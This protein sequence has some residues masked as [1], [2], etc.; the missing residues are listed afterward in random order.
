MFFICSTSFQLFIPFPRFWVQINQ[1]IPFLILLQKNP[2]LRITGP[3]VKP[4][5]SNSEDNSGNRN[6]VLFKMEKL[7]YSITQFPTGPVRTDR[8]DFIKML[9]TTR[10]K[11][12]RKKK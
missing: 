11:M 4:P 6:T 7:S 10:R 2:L 12:K 3:V 9:Y 5:N 1:N 8:G